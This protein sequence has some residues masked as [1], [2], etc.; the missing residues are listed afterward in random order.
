VIS[1]A[2]LVFTDNGNEFVREPLAD[3]EESW[4]KTFREVMG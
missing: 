4:T 3:L 1:E 2:E